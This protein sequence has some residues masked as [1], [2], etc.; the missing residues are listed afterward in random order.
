M[1]WGTSRHIVKILEL[2]MTYEEIVSD[3]GNRNFFPNSSAVAYFSPNSQTIHLNRISRADIAERHDTAAYAQ[4]RSEI[5]TIFHEITH[6]ADIVSTV[7]GRNHLL[8]IYDAFSLL[9]N[10]DTPGSEYEF[11]KFADLHDDQRRLMLPNYYRT[12]H[13]GGQKHDVRKTWGIQFSAGREFDPSGRLDDSRPILFVKFLD[14]DTGQQIIR[15]PLT[16]GSLL[17]ANAVW[18]EIR[19]GYEVLGTLVDGVR[20]VEQRIMDQE[21]LSYLYAEEL[22]LYTAPAHLLAHYTGITNVVLAYHLSSVVSHLTLNLLGTHY[23]MLQLPES[24]EIWAPLRDSF[25][26]RKNPGFAFAVICAC[27]KRWADGVSLDQWLNSALQNAGL[28]TSVEILDAAGEEL[29]RHAPAEGKDT[30]KDTLTYLLEIGISVFDVRRLNDDPS[31]T[32]GKA[33]HWEL[34]TP[35]L[36]DAD[37][38]ACI[39]AGSTFD[40]ARFDPVQMHEAEWELD[41]WTRNFLS[42]CR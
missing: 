35:P 32:L 11:W 34:P 15:Q 16:V 14:R 6:W 29:F 36:F 25:V 28:P 20:Q 9:R 23:E 3:L 21:L 37:G 40:L 26:A 24:M 39:T 2:K 33:L 4:A 1:V 12:V 5:A 8:K 17:E 18:S 13:P 22:T 30:F 38:E 19:A 27:S 31:L 41:K 10:V 7:W 42:S